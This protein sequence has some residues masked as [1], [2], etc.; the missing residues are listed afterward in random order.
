MTSV[1]PTM[2]WTASSAVSVAGSAYYDPGN[3]WTTN[4][5]VGRGT[6]QTDYVANSMQ[7]Y[8]FSCR[9]VNDDPI[10]SLTLKLSV[11]PGSGGY[12]ESH[13]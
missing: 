10:Y 8:V 13:W 1:S 4:D 6:A 9:D 7:D 12:D 11:I 5:L 2:S 3:R